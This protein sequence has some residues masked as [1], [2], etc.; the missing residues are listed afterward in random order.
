MVAIVSGNN[1]GLNLGSL[2]SLGTGG[3]FGNA[4]LGQSGE[5]SYVNVSTGN[6][7]L[8]EMD[9]ALFGIGGVAATVRTYNSQGQFDHDNV[10]GWRGAPYRSVLLQG[11]GTLLRTDIDGSS[12][13][14]AWDADEGA[15]LAVLTAGEA[16]DR[17]SVDGAGLYV[18]TDGTTGRVETYQGSGAGL[19][20]SSADTSGNTLAYTY[21]ASNRLERVENQAGEA[22]NYT[23]AGDNLVQVSSE[24]AGGVVVQEVSYTYDALNRLQS[25]RVALN[26]N[27]DLPPGATSSATY[28]TTYTYSGDSTRVATVT[29]GDGTRLS[30]AYVLQGGSYKVSSVTDGL[31]RI[32]RFAYNAATLTTTVT[33]ALGVA[34]TYRYDAAGQLAQVK[35][36]VTAANPNGLTQLSYTYDSR[37]NALSITDG[38]GQAVTFEYDARGNQTLQVDALGNRLER[39]FDDSNQL[40][41]ETVYPLADQPLTSR[42]VYDGDGRNLLRFSISADGRVTEHTYDED[43]LRLSTVRYTGGTYDVAS[44]DPEDTISLQALLDWTQSADR[45]RTERTDFTYDHRG[46]LHTRTTFDTVAVDGAGVGAGTSTVYIYSQEGELL[47]T[48]TPDG[49]TST[50]MV[51]DGLGRLVT[52]STHAT[53][54]TLDQTTTTLYDD[55]NSRSTLV[56]AN[57][58][59]TVSTYDRT[60]RVTSVTQ[61]AGGPT[62][63]T[64]RF[65]YD[66]L[67]NLVMTE[68]A[69]GLRQFMLYDAASRKVADI[70]ADGQ[71]TEYVYD[72]DSRLTQTIAYEAKANPAALVGSTGQPLVQWNANPASAPAGTTPVTLASL[73]TPGAAGERHWKFYDDADRLTFEVDGLGRVTQLR[74]DGA[75]RVIGTNQL[76]TRIDTAQLADGRRLELLLG[77]YGTSMDLWVDALPEGA[78]PNAART[79]SAY[80]YGNSAPTG[81][82]SFYL[83]ATLLG[84]AE[85]QGGYATLATNNLP[86][87]TGQITA[88]YSGDADNMV[89]STYTEIDVLPATVSGTALAVSAS[90][91]P[92]G[93]S[94]TLTATVSGATPGGLVTFYSGTRAVAV[95]TLVDGVAIAEVN[96]LPVG[97]QSLRAVYEGDD[98]NITSTSAVVTE[99]VTH[100]PST[101]APTVTTLLADN[102]RTFAGAPVVLTVQVSGAKP[103]G[104]VNFYNGSTLVGTATLANGLASVTLG[105]LPAGLARLQARYVGDT[106]NAASISAYVNTTV[107]AP[108]TVAVSASSATP[109]FG[110]ALTLTAA[111]S[112]TSPAG[113]VSFFRDGQL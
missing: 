17:I 67:G 92:A 4:A 69:T 29:Q 40:V 11:D 63:G 51:Y 86:A 76:A 41:A 52:S 89:S 70:G 46:Q 43:G 107:L 47:Q 25:V 103:G 44:L 45:S 112:G 16:L 62:L 65:V 24:L 21:N 22:V 6:L 2:A 90:T 97:T 38:L 48:I 50:Q 79:L 84:V 98:W 83:G 64:S 88:V 106:Q 49:E 113:V 68:D 53:D 81:T 54:G 18:F 39:A 30:F 55:T 72:A 10:D 5:R 108:V 27:G 99:V 94:L 56:L 58:L 85:I 95:A 35:M 23:Y 100:A 73:R 74:Y 59:R 8:Q 19:I 109:A 87:G 15:Y 3:Q 78:G 7:V 28:T 1:L 82:V 75:G 36:G 111:V 13:S 20:L 33:D 57:G 32:T 34:S 101:A 105:S 26:P 31:G 80:V 66:A 9:A 12:K 60:G 102:S 71:I 91:T 14:F 61:N 110:E 96:D 42:Y 37:G 104:T 93:T 77:G